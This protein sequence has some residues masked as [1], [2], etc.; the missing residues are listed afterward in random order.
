M[1]TFSYKIVNLFSDKWDIVLTNKLTD[2]S[3][4]MV[5]FI[6]E[7]NKSKLWNLNIWWFKTKRDNRSPRLNCCQM[8]SCVWDFLKIFSLLHGVDV[9]QQ[10]GSTNMSAVCGSQRFMPC[11]MGPVS[12]KQSFHVPWVKELPPSLLC[13]CSL[14]TWDQI[15]QVCALLLIYST[16]YRTLSPWSK[17]FLPLITFFILTKGPQ[18]LSSYIVISVLQH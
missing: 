13:L 18:F 1:I 9:F 11:V 10:T 12:C 15:Q 3:K 17:W 5:T 16:V 2:M 8:H 4:K 14:F 7:Q 6:G